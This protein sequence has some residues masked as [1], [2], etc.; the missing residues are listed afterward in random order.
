MFLRISLRQL[1]ELVFG[2]EFVASLVAR[3]EQSLDD[4]DRESI[5]ANVKEFHQAH[6]GHLQTAPETYTHPT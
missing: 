2:D 5:S 1:R 3:I 4:Q 6:I